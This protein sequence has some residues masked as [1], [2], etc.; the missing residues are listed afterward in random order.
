VRSVEIRPHPDIKVLNEL[1]KYDENTCMVDKQ[2]SNLPDS[3]PT[4]FES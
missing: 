2:V 4:E 3:S 1:G